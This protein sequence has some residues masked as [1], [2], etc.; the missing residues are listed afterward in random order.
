MKL[1]TYIS[2][3]IVGPLF[4]FSG[5]IKAND[6]LGFSYKLEEYFVE[7]GMDWEWLLS[8]G[9]FLATFI[10][11]LEVILGVAI[12]IGYKIKQVSILSLLMMLFF[13]VL[14]GAS[15]IYDLVRTCGCFGDAIPLTPEQ[16]FVKDLILDVLVFII[17]WQRK[18]IQPIFSSKISTGIMLATILAS[19]Y[20][21]VYCLNNLPV[22]DF[23]P[24]KVG[25]N[26]P[27]QMELP[28]GAKPDVYENIFY[29]KNKQ[30]GKVEE[31]N[32]SNYPWDDE[33][34]EFVD[35]ET[36]LIQKGDEAP[37]HDF[38]IV[39]PDGNDYT[40]DILNDPDYI[41]VV[42]AYNL[43][44][45]DVAAYKK[46]NNFA[47]QVYADGKSIIGLSASLPEVV[48]QFKNDNQVMIDFYTT[49]EVT[50]KTIIRSNPGILLLKQGTIVAKWHYNKLSDYK[51][52]KNNY[53]K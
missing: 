30:T 28:E 24:Y 44:K 38:N 41:F 7:F 35:R 47:E 42:V 19:I 20:F 25:K 9:V 10:C 39:G 43:N 8:M 49:D 5:I 14:T 6:P 46:I 51:D 40:E 53:L 26:I 13:T 16:S 11:V 22:W 17:F 3:L 33:N 15:A 32:E 21:P 18:N 34:Y 29:Y 23:R 36:K 37:I 1:L 50:L 2:R 27:E 4:I 45:T 52:V 48:E 31:F 12:I